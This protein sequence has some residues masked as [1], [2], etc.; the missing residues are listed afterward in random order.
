MILPLNYLKAYDNGKYDFRLLEDDAANNA[1]LSFLNHNIFN[2]YAMLFYDELKDCFMIYPNMSV[3]KFAV[4]HGIIPSGYSG[5]EDDVIE[6]LRSAA[7][8]IASPDYL[9][10]SFMEQRVI[11][12]LIEYLKEYES[13]CAEI[14]QISPEETVSDRIKD[15]I[16]RGL[17][18]H[19]EDWGYECNTLEESLANVLNLITDPNN[20]EDIFFDDY[21]FLFM[22]EWAVDEDTLA[23]MP[24]ADFANMRAMTNEERAEEESLRKSIDRKYAERKIVDCWLQEEQKNKF[25]SFV[26]YDRDLRKHELQ[27]RVKLTPTTHI[28]DMLKDIRDGNVNLFRWVNSI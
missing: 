22:D 4:M 14:D 8:V 15:P 17:R 6:L 27:R 28:V 7:D 2:A 16:K 5:S 10:P 23:R 24:I 3:K 26:P 20:Y 13:F 11:Y 12:G 9:F 1:A 18:D 25:F 21:D 19:P